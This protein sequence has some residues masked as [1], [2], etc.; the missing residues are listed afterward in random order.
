MN[1]LQVMLKNWLMVS[2]PVTEAAQHVHS[3][4][5]NNTLFPTGRTKS[6]VEGSAPDIAIVS[7]S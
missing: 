1:R 5:D 3:T 6:F 4:V 7:G 2:D